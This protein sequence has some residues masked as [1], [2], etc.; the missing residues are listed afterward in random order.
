MMAPVFLDDPHFNFIPYNAWLAYG[1]SKTANVLMAVEATRRWANAGI[2]ANALNPGAIQTNLQRH[3]GGKLVTP[4]EKQKTTQ[5]GAATSVLLA[6]SQQ[7][8]GIGGRY[9]ENCSRPASSTGVRM[10]LVAVSLLM[11]SIRKMPSG[12]GALQLK[13][14]RRNDGNEFQNCLACIFSNSSRHASLRP[15][16]R[17]IVPSMAISRSSTKL[18]FGS[19]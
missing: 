12:F 5:Q 16:N 10:I 9:F 3:V 18:L 8:E 11:L 15:R 14:W 13:C 2:F 17:S 19:K 6:T 7:L 4:P 1:Q